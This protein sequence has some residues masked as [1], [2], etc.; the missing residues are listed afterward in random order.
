MLQGNSCLVDKTISDSPARM[1]RKPLGVVSTVVRL[2][3]EQKARIEKLV[4]KNGRA[5]FIREAIDAELERR[6]G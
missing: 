5:K 6:E 2:T 3:S 4:G 1:G